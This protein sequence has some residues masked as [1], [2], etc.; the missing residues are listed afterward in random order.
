MALVKQEVLPD[1]YVCPNGSPI[2]EV[3]F[4]SMMRIGPLGLFHAYDCD[5]HIVKVH[6][7][8]ECQLWK[9]INRTP[10]KG[11]VELL[12]DLSFKRLN[13]L[14]GQEF[15]RPGSEF[16][17][18]Y[19]AVSVESIDWDKYD[20]VICL[21]IAVP[22]RI[23][24]KHPNT[25]WCYML[26]EPQIYMDK[27]YF[28]YD[29]SFNH[30]AVGITYIKPGIIDFPYTFLHPGLLTTILS[31]EVN[32]NSERSGIFCDVSCSKDEP[33]EV[34]VDEP[35]VHLMPL[36]KTGHSLLTH[37]QS[38][39]ENLLT[40]YDSKYFIKLGGS[41]IRGNS[42]IEA[43]SAGV[44][45]IANPNQVILKDLIPLDCR[46]Y[47]TAQTLELI[48]Y[49]E[50]NPEFFREQLYLQKAICQLLVIQRPMDSLGNILDYKRKFGPMKEGIRSKL[51]A[52]MKRIVN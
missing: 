31:K 45:V 37:K 5:Y 14:P 12:R 51:K 50:N 40:L 41:Y 20:I 44:L 34:F 30:N 39:K 52:V 21:N 8:R 27:V 35:P 16:A 19:F 38:I 42:I 13:E 23:I 24:M 10:L 33:K 2:N 1:L 7:A 48:S 47:N 22:T 18:G 43:I 36:T 3:L 6:S 17:N 26:Q 11:S 25:L 15:K 46:V 28:G 9:E 29:V 32:R 49:L 4:S